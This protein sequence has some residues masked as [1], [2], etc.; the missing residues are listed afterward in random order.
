MSKGMTSDGKLGVFCRHVSD[1]MS[2]TLFRGG[3]SHFRE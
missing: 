2:L 3:Q 1:D